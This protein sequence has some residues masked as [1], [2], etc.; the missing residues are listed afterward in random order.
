MKMSAELANEV[1]KLAET[2]VHIGNDG[3]FACLCEACR[4]RFEETRKYLQEELDSVF[5]EPII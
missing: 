4:K 1:R 5:S 3:P 2:R